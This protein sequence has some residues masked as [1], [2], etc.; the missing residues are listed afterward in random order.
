MDRDWLV[1]IVPVA[2]VWVM[3]LSLVSAAYLLSGS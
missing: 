1:V 3:I 2:F